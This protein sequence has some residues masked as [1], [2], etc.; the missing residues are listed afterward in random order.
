MD[1]RATASLNQ[2]TIVCQLPPAM[3][4]N[5]FCLLRPTVHSQRHVSEFEVDIKILTRIS[6]QDIG[7][8]RNL[9]PNKKTRHFLSHFL[10]YSRSSITHLNAPKVFTFRFGRVSYY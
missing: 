8:A 6:D 9:Q 4:D 10:L 7:R 5:I 2:L 3:P 1:N